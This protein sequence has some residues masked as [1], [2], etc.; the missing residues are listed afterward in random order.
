M[1]Q[2]SALGKSVLHVSCIT[3]PV[4]EGLYELGL[5]KPIPCAEELL[6][7]ITKARLGS[8]NSETQTVFDLLGM[9]KNGGK[10]L[11]E[12]LVGE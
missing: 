6:Q 12:S 5:L 8:I 1:I 11:W 2:A 9:P 7:A 3:S 4:S 10:L